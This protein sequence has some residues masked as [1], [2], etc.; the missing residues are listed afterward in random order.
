MRVPVR[1][2]LPARHRWGAKNGRKAIF[3]VPEIAMTPQTIRRV[4]ARFPGR[5]GL[6]HSRLSEGERYDTWRR[7]RLGL[8]D[9]IIRPPVISCP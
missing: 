2:N 1:R 9:I 4:V 7:K 8:L 5:V 3:L 6:I